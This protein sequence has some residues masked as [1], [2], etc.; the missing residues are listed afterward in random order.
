MKN[1][2][3]PAG[4]LKQDA[5]PLFCDKGVF[6]IMVDI[7]LQKQ[8]QFRNLIPMLGGCHTAKF[9]QH[10]IGKYVRGSGLEE[11]LRQTRIFGVKIVNCVLD[12]TH[13]M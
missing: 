12:G 5:V 8:D 2:T 11:S 3:R 13:Y 10:S 7:F 6:R 9:L 4:Q 1:F